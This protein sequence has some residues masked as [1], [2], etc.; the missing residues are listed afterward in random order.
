MG[1]LFDRTPVFSLQDSPRRRRIVMKRFPFAAFII[2]TICASVFLYLVS[3]GG[4]GGGGVEQQSQPPG[5]I[6]I[7]AGGVTIFW[8]PYDTNIAI[9]QGNAVQETSDHGFIVAGNQAPDFFLPNDVFLMKTDSTGA[10][11]WKKRFAWAGGAEANSVRQAN[12]G[13]Y[14]V[15]GQ[16]K[17]PAGSTNVYLLKTDATGSTA[18]GW[19]K[20]FGGTEND[21]G[22]SVLEVSNGYMIAGSRGYLDANK[23]EHQTIYIIRTNTTGSVVWERYNYAS[24][25]PGGSEA[26]RALAATLDNNYVIA[27]TT[28][29]FGWKGFLLKIDKDGNEVWRN[30]YGT[31]TAS[32]EGIYSVA[33]APDGFVLAGK[34]S[35]V[36][37]QPPLT[38]PADALVIKTDA[39]GTELWRRTYGG[40]DQDEAFAVALTQS[41]DYLVFGYSQ[42][43]GGTVNPAY[44]WQYQDVFLMKLDG[45]GNTIW[46]KVKGNRPAGSDFGTTGAVVSDG[47]FVVS[48]SSG[49]NVLLAK[50]DGNGETIGLGDTDLTL[51]I[52]GNMGM[53]TFGNAIDVTASGVTAIKDA[54]DAGAN[55]VDLLIATL[56]SEPVSDFCSSGSYTFSPAPALPLSVS[57]FT[58][59]FADCETGPA[60]DTTLLNGSAA[61]IISSVSGSNDL[62]TQNYTVQTML[63][64]ISITAAETAGTL[65]STITGS[66]S[67][68]RQA[69]SGNFVEVAQSISDTSRLTFI[70]SDGTTTLMRDLGPFVV[71]ASISSSGTYSYGIATDSATVE[72]GIG[73]LTITIIQPIQGPSLGAAPTGGIIE[74]TATD[75]SILTATIT[76]G[77][78]TMAVDTNGDGTVDGSVSAPWDFL[79]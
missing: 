41:N 74:I 30:K 45:S 52:P 12:D 44:S 29:C 48:G 28:G 73:P 20:T 3:C 25:C 14:V 37:G 17:M 55:A 2:A 47:G 1:I 58:L 11:Q 46:Q 51:N 22:Y 66:M 63:T 32:A 62:I 33:V 39:N 31:S 19:Q 61:L 26:G 21:I 34:R 76:N 71:H 27:G 67:F 78:A 15:V 50:F 79:D 72:Q 43:Y 13:G 65:S 42:S 9:G 59:T 18:G 68:A 64:S 53:I 38:G 23:Q 60:G 69:T 35:L 24:F 54:R 57:G 16:A 4:G 40:A 8:Y 6:G 5:G 77:T 70:E 75:N 10:V 56:K 7:G 49:G 36:N